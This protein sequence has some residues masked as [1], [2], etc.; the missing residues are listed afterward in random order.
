MVLISSIWKAEVN[1]QGKSGPEPQ[2]K[3]RKSMTASLENYQ[4]M[5]KQKWKEIKNTQNNWKKMSRAMG[6]CLFLS[7]NLECQWIK[8]PN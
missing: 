1:I 6:V 5:G 3:T 7:H 2:S 8:F 4:H